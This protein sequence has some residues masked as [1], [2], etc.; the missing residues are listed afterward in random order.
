MINFVFWYLLIGLINTGIANTVNASR[1]R[2]K[3]MIMKIFSGS[4]K[5][6]RIIL[7]SAII[8]IMIWPFVL[9]LN[10]YIVYKLLK[11]K[12]TGEPK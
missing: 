9:P 10:L 5:T 3:I 1:L 11:R 2:L 12:L 6:Y 8:G 4:F 7:F